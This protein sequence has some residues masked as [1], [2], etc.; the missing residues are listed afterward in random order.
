PTLA[1][2]ETS[3]AFPQAGYFVMRSGWS[4]EAVWALFDGGPLGYTHHHED[5]LNLLLH[6][7]GRLLLTECGN[8]AFDDSEMR[9]YAVS[10]RGHNTVRVD[11]MDQ[12][13]RRNFIKTDV[14]VRADCGAHWL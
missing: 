14:N 8:Y 12:N 13:R 10:T 6:G 9:R 11:G 7:H 1:P 3:V 2:A 4:R 5:K